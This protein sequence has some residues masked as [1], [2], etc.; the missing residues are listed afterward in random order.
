MTIETYEDFLELLKNSPQDFFTIHYACKSFSSGITSIAIKDYKTAK[1][2][3]YSIH[4]IAKE[5][6]IKEDD[7]KSRF[8]EIELELLRQFYK[9][10]KKHK[11]KYWV[12]W[13]MRDQG[14]G[15]EH[16]EHRYRVLIKKDAPEIP[17]VNR[18]NLNDMLAEEH[19][20]LYAGNP[21]MSSLMK[22]NGEIYRNFLE[23]KEEVQAFN[24]GEFDKIERST[25]AK[26]GFFGEVMKKMTKGTLKTAT[27][28][29]IV[30]IDK[31]LVLHR[32]KF[33]YW[34]FSLLVKIWI[35]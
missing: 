13:N 14:F 4:A 19:G 10:V 24:A 34:L 31:F 25:S 27:G 32:W 16:L 17:A 1:V 22:I 20:G 12:H 29:Y 3:N 2:Y 6:D 7:I 15:F 26:V 11:H 35:G 5:R 18:I 9:L 23:G 30:A 33:I 28:R 21:K 8:N